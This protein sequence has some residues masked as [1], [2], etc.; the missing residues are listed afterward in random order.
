[1][2]YETYS[3]PFTGSQDEKVDDPIMTY[4]PNQPDEYLQNNSEQYHLLKD[5]FP[6]IPREENV[7]C[8][9]NS[10]NCRNTDFGKLLEPTGNFR[11]ITNNYKHGYPDSCLTP[12]QEFVLSFY[13]GSGM[14]VNVPKDCN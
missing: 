7:A 10:R 5:V 4:R 14:N 1:M 9:V 13:K 2:F 3:E 11:Q 6:A 8:N 12:F